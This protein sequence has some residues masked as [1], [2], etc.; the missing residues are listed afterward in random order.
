MPCR[1]VGKAQHIGLP[2]SKVFFMVD[3]T[4]ASEVIG[5]FWTCQQHPAAAV[6]R[7]I[8]NLPASKK[9]RGSRLSL[10]KVI[11][12]SMEVGH[13]Q[14]SLLVKDKSGICCTESDL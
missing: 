7:D 2:V 14:Y 3:T 13:D 5:V 10:S 9:G 12:N 11:I 8:L 1:P 6:T 4:L